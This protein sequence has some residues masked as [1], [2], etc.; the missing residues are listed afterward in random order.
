[1]TKCSTR[2]VSPCATVGRD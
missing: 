1:M 2:Y